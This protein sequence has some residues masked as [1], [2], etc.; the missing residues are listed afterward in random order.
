MNSSV[1]D[2]VNR[3]IME[4]IEVKNELRNK[5]EATW[6]LTTTRRTCTAVCK[7]IENEILINETNY[8][9]NK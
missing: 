7:T 1:T 4:D 8:K 6:L 5:L 9:I 3:S 2:E